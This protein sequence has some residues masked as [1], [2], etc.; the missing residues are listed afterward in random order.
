MQYYVKWY[1][2]ELNCEADQAATAFPGFILG[3]TSS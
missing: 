3:F 1:P 2:I